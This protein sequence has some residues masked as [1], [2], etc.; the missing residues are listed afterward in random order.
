MPP[1]MIAVPTRPD[2]I[3]PPSDE[4]SLRPKAT[5]GAAPA[6]PYDGRVSHSRE[7]VG[8]FSY[9]G[10]KA[11]VTGGGRGIGRAIALA[12]ARQGADIAIAA[13]RQEELDSGARGIRNLRRKA[14]V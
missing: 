11:L 2:A 7:E 3:C 14:V 5:R 8:M 13:R 6:D 12:F 1:P 10:K 9:E 4:V